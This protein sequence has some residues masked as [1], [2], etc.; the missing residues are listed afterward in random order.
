MD[1]FTTL[2]A[3]LLQLKK[4]LAEGKKIDSWDKKSLYAEK[5][6]CRQSRF[7][8]SDQ[9]IPAA[10]ATVSDDDIEHLPPEIEAMGLGRSEE[11]TSELQS[12]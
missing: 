8:L 7:N 4:E 12:P 6:L 11:H 5:S 10:G 1:S 3:V 2:E 9:C